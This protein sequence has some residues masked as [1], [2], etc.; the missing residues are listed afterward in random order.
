MCTAISFGRY[1]GRNLDWEH[2]FGEEIVVTPQNFPLKFCHGQTFSR[3][4]AFIGAA[5]PGYFPLYFDAANEKGLAAAG[6]NFPHF[7]HYNQ[8]CE[9]FENVASFEI[10][11]YV[12]SQCAS[13]SEAKKLLSRINITDDAFSPS[14]PPSPLH[15]IIADSSECLVLEQTVKGRT[16]YE[17]NVKILT[18]SP[19]FDMQLF[20]LSNFLNLSPCEGENRFSNKITLSP[21]SRG[22]GAFFLPGDFSS[23]SRF[24]KSA[25]LTL[26]SPK[27]I[28]ENENIRHLFNILGNVSQ[29]KGSNIIDGKSEYT[30]YSACINTAKGIYF[31]KTYNGT[32]RGVD[33]HSADLAA[34]ILISYPFSDNN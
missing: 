18:N 16:I 12:L 22:M 26:N 7:C 34:K 19:T 31:Y 4:Y 11:P 28:D 32:F 25:F 20:Y 27:F 30:I 6:L 14:M 1:F 10:I 23:P 33:M 13:V 15:F 8:Y 17:N 29:I 5:L 2:S 9:G 3:H 24:V 21:C